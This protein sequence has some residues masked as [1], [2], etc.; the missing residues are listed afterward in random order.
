LLRQNPTDRLHLKDVA[1]HV[2]ILK[3]GDIIAIE[4]SYVKRN[5]ILNREN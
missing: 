4:D 2:W 5:K 3:N 1:Q